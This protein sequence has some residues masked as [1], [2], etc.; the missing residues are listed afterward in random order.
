MT[1][2][3]CQRQ[4]CGQRQDCDHSNQ[5]CSEPL[6]Q[7]RQTPAPGG[8]FRIYI[9]KLSWTMTVDTLSKVYLQIRG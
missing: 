8:S 3:S 6:K 7:T 4:G 1:S 2:E 5:N 9:L